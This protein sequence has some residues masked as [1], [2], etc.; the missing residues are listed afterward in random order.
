MSNI[1]ISKPIDIKPKEKSKCRSSTCDSHEI[2]RGRFC[3]ECCRFNSR[4]Y[5]RRSVVLKRIIQD[6]KNMLM[7]SEIKAS[8]SFN[9]DNAG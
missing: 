1:E 7:L 9:I 6:K 3:K 8:K 4:M 5:Y 2:Y